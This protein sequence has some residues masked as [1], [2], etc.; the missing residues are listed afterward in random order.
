VLNGLVLAMHG[1]GAKLGIVCVD[2]DAHDAATQLQAAVDE[3][4][5]QGLLD[6]LEIRLQRVPTRYVAGEET[7]LLTVIEGGA[8]VPRMRPPFP[9]DVG[10]FGR[11]TLVQNVET[12]AQL[13]TAVALGPAA[14]RSVGTVD[15]PGS[16]VFTVGRF[17]GPFTVTERPFGYPLRELLAESG[18]LQGVRGVLVGGYAGGLLRSDA[19]DVAL[20]PLDLRGAGASLGTKSIQVLTADMCPVRV[21]ADIVDY[22]GGQTAD[23]CPPCHR[24]LPDMGEIL[25]GLESG[26]TGTAGLADLEEFMGTLAGRGVCRL[27]DGAARVALSLLT[28]FAEEVAT[29]VD[30]GCPAPAL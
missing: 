17:G 6:E 16:G 3:A 18:L 23:Q 25:R 19:L 20:T 24:G 9:S 21:V 2:D 26:S 12:L 8:P 5:R 4:A 27:P 22:F 11:P 1:V 10:V 29:H 15:T 28:N 13:A 14:Y 30:S 7:A